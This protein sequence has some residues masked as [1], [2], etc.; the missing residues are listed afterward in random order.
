VRLGPSSVP[1]IHTLFLDWRAAAFTAGMS[2]IVALISGVLPA[3]RAARAGLAS[4]GRQTATQNSSQHRLRAGLVVLEVALALILVTGAA[5]LARS[6]AGLLNV[7]TGFA[8]DRVLVAQVF[9]WDYN[10]TPAQLRTFFDATIERLQALPAVQDV[11]AVSAMP[12]IESNINIQNVFAIAGRPP[13][14][15]AEAPRA[16]LSV[17]SPGYFDAMRIPLKAGRLLDDRDGPDRA[18]VAVISETMARRY[19]LSLDDALGSRLRFRFSGTPAD[20]EVVGVVGSLRHETLDGEVRDELFMPLAQI[21]FGSMTFVVR[22]AGD[23]S[24]LLEPTRAAIWA[25]NPSQTIYRIATLDELVAKT[26]SPRRFALAVIVGFAGLALLLAV[27]GVYGLLSALMS[28]RQREVGL[29]VALGASRSDIIQLVVG[30]GLVLTTAGL[31]IGVSGALGAGR[32]LQ[33]FLFGITPA[34]PLAVGASAAFMW[35]AA[36]I[37][38]YLPARRAAGADP[39][40]VLRGE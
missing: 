11:G 9:A 2:L 10:P 32:M 33:S 37:A 24:A 36:L 5:L 17:A 12:F 1:W 19:W 21:P 18:R 29:R 28:A 35:F 38:C 13:P 16:Y 20:V 31:I 34:D 30:R 39:V 8:R 40:T 22:S 26:V 3:F 7:E 15:Q 27:A 6:F 4:A 14:T 25:I 23:A